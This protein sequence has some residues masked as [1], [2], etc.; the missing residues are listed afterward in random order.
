VKRRF[1]F[2]LKNAQGKFLTASLF[3]ETAIR[4][5]EALF[6]LNPDHPTLPS[7]HEVY[8]EYDDPT[9][10]G[11]AMEVFGELRA[12]RMVSES[13]K[14]KEYVD[15]WREELEIKLRSR[16]INSLS[17]KADESPTAARWLAETGYK[18]RKHPSSKARKSAETQVEAGVEEHI[19]RNHARLTRVK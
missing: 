16:A 7:M 18:I 6:S 10:Y 5:E 2:P 3:W 9:E 19:K 14:I 4:Q 17:N 12:W 1:N 11:F 13:P 15:A 8:R